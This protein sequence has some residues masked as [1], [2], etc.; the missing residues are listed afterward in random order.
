MRKPKALLIL[1]TLLRMG[2][3]NAFWWELRVARDEECGSPH[4]VVKDISPLLSSYNG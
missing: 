1:Q 2:T 3:E 4:E